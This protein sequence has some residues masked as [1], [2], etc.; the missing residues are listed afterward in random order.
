MRLNPFR[1]RAKYPMLELARNPDAAARAKRT[2]DAHSAASQTGL[3][4][5]HKMRKLV[6]QLRRDSGTFGITAKMLRAQGRHAE[7]VLLEAL[8]NPA[9]LTLPP[10]SDH[11]IDSPPPETVIALLAD[12]GSPASVP[13]LTRLLDH[14][15]LGKAALRVYACLCD[16][17]MIATLD[18]RIEHQGEDALDTICLGLGNRFYENDAEPEVRQAASEL[19]AAHLFDAEDCMNAKVIETMLKIDRDKGLDALRCQRALMGTQRNRRIAIRELSHI[20]GSLP[21]QLATRLLETETDPVLQAGIIRAAMPALEPA[22]WR[23]AVDRLLRQTPSVEDRFHRAR[24]AETLLDIIAIWLGHESAPA[25]CGV[26]LQADQRT[27]TQ[28]ELSD[29][30]SF[31]AEV[32]NGGLMQYFFNSSGARWRSVLKALERIGAEQIHDLLQRAAQTIGATQSD[33][34]REQLHARLAKLTQQQEELLSQLDSAYYT[35]NSTLWV[36][37]AKHIAQ[38]RALFARSSAK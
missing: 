29:I 25:L 14:D 18:K 23:P 35:Q 37:L 24:L 36:A 10:A 5:E 13:A 9:F 8:N 3:L 34:T 22:V 31:D 2:L 1:K 6:K 4:S 20:S 26:E 16:A 38:N 27:P 12:C 28:R 7:G 32:C 30:F 19:L 21:P 17:Q 33:Q 15:S 11:F